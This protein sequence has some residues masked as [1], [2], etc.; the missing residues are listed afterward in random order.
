MDTVKIDLKNCYGIKAL[1]H[2]FHF[3]KTRAYALYAP[4]GVMKS[5]LAKTFKDAAQG[6]ESTDRIFPARKT[7]RSIVDEKGK[8]I[9]GDRV[10]VITPYDRELG[11]T[12]KTS[13]LLLNPQ[14][15]R[16]YDDLLRATAAAKSALLDA[17]QTQADTKADPAEEISIAVMQAPGE[18]DAALIRLRREVAEQ[19]DNLFSTVPYDTVFNE[20]V[21]AALNT[22]DLKSAV[23]DYMEHYNKLLEGSTY[24]KKGTFDYYNAD[25]IAKSL[26]DNGFFEAHHT[27]SLKA[28]A[29]DREIRTQAELQGVVAEE[30]S[31]ILT[32]AKLRKKFDDVAKQ[33]QKNVELRNFC[34]Y[35]Q[36]QEALLARL[37]NPERLRQDVLKS[38]IKTHEG[39]YNDWLAKYE[40]ADKRRKELEETAKAQQSQW[41]EVIEIFNDRFVVP[42]KLEAKNEAEVALGQT[43]IIELGFTYIDGD[44]KASLAKD[45]LLKSLSTGESKALYVLNVIFE[46]ETRRKEKQETIIVVDDIADSF[47]YQNKYAIIQYLKD[48]SEYTDGLFKMIVMTHNFDFFRTIFYR[49][50]GY[51]NCLTASRNDNGVELVQASAI[52]NVFARDWKK[53]FFEDSKKKIASIPFLRNL[54]EMT[55]GEDDPSY[56]RLTAMLHWKAE[57]PK[58]TVADLDALYD[59]ICRTTGASKNSKKLI[60]ELIVEQAEECAKKASA[61][62]EN[63]IVLAIAIRLLSEKFMVDRIANP[64]FVASI[65]SNQAGSLIGKFKELFPGEDKNIKT[66]EKVAIMTPENI[67]VNAFMYEPIIDMS[68]DSLRRLYQRVKEL[69]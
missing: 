22:K 58:L 38:Y 50:V 59:D 6:L 49:F 9:E 24:F 18:S 5:S 53:H 17:L 39:L 15:K 14:M 47:D 28:T 21:V 4:N 26:T 7:A 35:V 42:F 25:Q 29:G 37:D 68:D 12:E 19:K 52:K 41:K 57:T 51:A 31:R 11:I 61:G 34:K 36:D 32:D 2:D 13:T 43:N 33:L 64:E 8:E 27:V 66:L 44:D 60:H 56:L 45:D 16:E 30:K 55:V 3:K 62:L 65:D 69:K 46:I 40:A 48:I 10:F 23:K 54:V 67:H 1:K 20:K 63:K